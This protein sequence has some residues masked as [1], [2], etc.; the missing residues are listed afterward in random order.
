MVVKDMRVRR[1][2]VDV[3]ASRGSFGDVLGSVLV[4]SGFCAVDGAFENLGIDVSNIVVEVVP[5]Y[6]L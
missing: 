2:G 3:L 6:H 4:D 5:W 1:L